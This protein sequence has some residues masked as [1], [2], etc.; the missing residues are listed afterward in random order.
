MDS[1]DSS[2]DSVYN[3]DNGDF[4]TYFFD[5][6]SEDEYNEFGLNLNE[7]ERLERKGHSNT[8]SNT[9]AI[10]KNNVTY[11]NSNSSNNSPPLQAGQGQGQGQIQG[12]SVVNSAM[13]MNRVSLTIGSLDENVGY[14]NR[15]SPHI[16][17]LELKIEDSLR[18]KMEMAMGQ[19][20]Q[21]ALQQH[22]QQQQQMNCGGSHN[23][24]KVG[25][26]K[27]NNNGNMNQSYGM[28]GMSG[29]GEAQGMHVK[30]RPS[31]YNTMLTELS[32]GQKRRVFFFCVC[33]VFFGLFDL[34]GLLRRC[35]SEIK[36]AKKK[37]RK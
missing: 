8:N 37:L 22:T 29:M 2:T 21:Q 12:Q 26:Q 18:E 25:N 6:S 11:S 19:Q 14:L 20:Q 9:N 1:D 35:Q 33:A 36:Q 30:G 16:D 3:S 7:K 28:S 10:N 32:L 27:I 15:H 23:K 13:H 4:D 17:D 24:M 34:F 31:I 5:D